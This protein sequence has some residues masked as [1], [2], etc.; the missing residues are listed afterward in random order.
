M[1]D[2]GVVG[3]IQRAGHLGA[4]LGQPDR[5]QRALLGDQVGQG[6]GVDQLHHDEHVSA[7]LDH[8][9]QDDRRGMVEPGRRPGLAHHPGLGW[10]ALLLGHGGREHHLLDRDLAIQHQILGTPDNTHPS[11]P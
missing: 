1:Q 2:P 4:D 7:V 11:P 9:V 5:R 3:G 10:A 8:V 6:R